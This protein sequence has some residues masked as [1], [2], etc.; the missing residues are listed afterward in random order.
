MS[1]SES[2]N[3][4]LLVQQPGGDKVMLVIAVVLNPETLDVERLLSG[5]VPEMA[6][7]GVRGG[8][9]VIG[10]STLVLRGRDAEIAVDEVDT[11]EL[12]ALAG[13]EERWRRESIVE[14]MQRWVA[15]LAANWRDRI[16]DEQM[17]ALLVPYVVAGLAGD[18]EVVDG[19]WGSEAH[20]LVEA[21]Q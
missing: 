2:E 1:E 4:S 18:V 7:G 13:I 14:L 8:L 12:L 6:R 5:L 20:R 11:A 15:G 17:R 19:I 9:L 3:K 16:V 21:E 10:D